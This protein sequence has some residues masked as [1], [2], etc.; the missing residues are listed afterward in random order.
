MVELTKQV[1]NSLAQKI[2]SFG[3]WSD[4][5]LELS[6]VN[7]KNKSVKSVKDDLLNLMSRNPA[8]N[9]VLDYA[10]SDNIQNSISDLLDLNR[11]GEIKAKEKEEL[12]EW[13]KINHFPVLMA[14]KAA[15]RIK[16]KI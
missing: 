12:N 1:S 6:L 14:A 9:D 5:I 11:E 3:I 4:I 15:K 7:F 10:L 2:Q 8:D 13:L 16:G